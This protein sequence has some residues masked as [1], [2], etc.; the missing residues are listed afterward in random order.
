[1]D[2]AIG[3][4]R[5]CLAD[6][7]AGTSGSGRTHH[8]FS[9]VLFLETQRFFERVRVRLVQLEAGVLI[10][11]PGLRFVDTKLPLACDDLFDAD[12]NL[13]SL[14]AISSQLSAFSSVLNLLSVRDASLS[15]QKT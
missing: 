11:N 10:A 3:T 1:M 12:R 15:M 14:S 4:A 8:H 6:D 13:H 7:L 9:A 5:Q 2:S